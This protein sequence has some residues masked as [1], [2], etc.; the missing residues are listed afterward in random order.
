MIIIQSSLVHYTYT[1]N[2]TKYITFQIHPLS[3]FILH[4]TKLFKATLSV[5]NMHQRRML[6]RL[7]FDIMSESLPTVPYCVFYNFPLLHPQVSNYSL[8]YYNG[9]RYPIPQTAM[10]VLMEVIKLITTILRSKG[11]YNISPKETI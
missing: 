10:V 4:S 11:R 8:Q 7:M 5:L 6:A 2:Y 1:Y 3:S 9:G